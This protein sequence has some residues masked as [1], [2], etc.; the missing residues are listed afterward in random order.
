[1][2]TRVIMEEHYT[3]CQHSMPFVLNGLTHFFSVLQYTADVIV[4]PCCM[5]STI[6]TPF[7]CQKTVAISFLAENV[8]LNVFGF[9]GECVCMHC[10]DCSLVSAFTN[11][12]QVSWLVTRTML[13]RNSSASLWY[14]FKM[15]K[16]KP[17]SAF[18]VHP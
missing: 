11:E 5:N 3:G 10:F 7:L 9:S 18:L 4:V 12:A 13:L 2:R 16:A 1:M 14:R 15:V 17:F 8:C 6:S